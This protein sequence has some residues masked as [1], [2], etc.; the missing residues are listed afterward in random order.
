MNHK[1]APAFDLYPQRWLAGTLDMTAEER[2]AY[3][4]LLC[5]QWEDNGLVD[6]VKK[7]AATARCRPLVLQQILSKFPLC[8]DGLRR[9]ARLEAVRAEQRKRIAKSREKIEKMNAGRLAKAAAEAAADEGNASSTRTST[10]GPTREGETASTRGSTRPSSPLTT[11]HSPHSFVKESK[12]G[13]GDLA[14]ENVVLDSDLPEELHAAWAEWQSYRQT[15]AKA[16]GTQRLAW[17]E[18]AARM[19][20]KQVRDYSST[21]GPKIVCDRIASAIGGHWQGLNLDKLELPRGSP[22][23]PAAVPAKSFAQTD[24]EAR[25]TAR[26]GPEA[27]TP[28]VLTLEQLQLQNE[29]SH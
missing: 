29:S 15:R 6:D 8:E 26:H 16:K 22:H 21:M 7:L 13:D 10:R 3:I 23:H 25:R 19:G 27:I 20:A 11:H 4:T 28:K 18:Q 14:A 1:D 2:G 9:N 5:K 12:Q 24:L 17:T